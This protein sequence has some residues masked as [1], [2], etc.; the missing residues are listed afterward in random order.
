MAKVDIGDEVYDSFISLDKADVY[1]AGDILRAVAWSLSNDDAKGRGLVSATRLLEGLPWVEPPTMVDT[2]LVVQQVTAMLAADLLA[3][4]ALLA[5]A[6]GDSNVKS[7]KAG[8]AAVEFFQP[9]EGGPLIPGALWRLLLN[10]GLVSV[11]STDS[12]ENAGAIVT[13]ILSTRRPLCGRYPGDYE[14]SSAD[15]G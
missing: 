7:V 15:F 4:P 2:P 14:I 8:S 13:G 5:N 12:G 10:A 6:S 1:L 11:G 3:D 9:I